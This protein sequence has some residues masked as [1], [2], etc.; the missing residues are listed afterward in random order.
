MFDFA[1]CNVALRFF[2]IALHLKSGV[3][4]KG[5]SCYIFLLVIL[6]SFKQKRG[7][8]Q[9]HHFQCSSKGFPRLQSELEA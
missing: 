4:T 8:Q 1:V 3:E 2:I 7:E 5:E 6:T 9:E